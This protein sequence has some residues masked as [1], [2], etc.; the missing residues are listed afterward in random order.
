MIDLSFSLGGCC[1]GEMFDSVSYFSFFL[2]QFSKD[3]SGS[4]DTW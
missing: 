4:G 1:G 2:R 3:Y